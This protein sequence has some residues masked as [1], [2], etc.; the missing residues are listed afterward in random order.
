MT[1]PEQHAANEANALRSTGPR[2]E[3]GMARAAQNAVR[4]GLLGRFYLIVG[5][6]PAEYEAFHDHL[7]GELNPS[8]ALEEAL[9][10]RIIEAFW[11]LQRVGRIEAEMMDSIFEAARASEQFTYPPVISSPPPTTDGHQV[12]LRPPTRPPEPKPKPSQVSL[13]AAVKT[14]MQHSDVIGKFHRYEAHIERGLFRALHEFQRLQ[15]ARQGQAVP[16]PVALDITTDLHP[17]K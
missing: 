8:G 10:E 4:H 13:G 17:D 5:E 11:R 9:T 2:T 14:Q 15:A 7:H 16:A 1:S 6:D 12:F 3:A